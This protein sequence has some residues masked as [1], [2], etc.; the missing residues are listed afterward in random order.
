MA[1]AGTSSGEYL[2]LQGTPAQTATSTDETNPEGSQS[3]RKKRWKQKKSKKDN[4]EKKPKKQK[5][6]GKSVTREK[7]TRGHTGKVLKRKY[8]NEERAEAEKRSKKKKKQKQQEGRQQSQGR[9]GHEIESTDINKQTHAEA[10]PST[11]DADPNGLVRGET[12]H[13]E[14]FYLKIDEDEKKNRKGKS[15]I[16][17]K[18]FYDDVKDLLVLNSF[19]YSRLFF[20]T[21]VLYCKHTWP[22]RAKENKNYYNYEQRFKLIFKLKAVGGSRGEPPP[23]EKHNEMYLVE[24][25][26]WDKY[27]KDPSKFPLRRLC[28]Y[29]QVSARTD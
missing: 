6:G 25:S 18:A 26:N 28:C 29:E 21:A 3:T 9:D 19:D 11:A 8:N 20:M 15:K 2:E 7:D 12:S 5:Q 10:N 17:T 4:K 14:A 24:K 13:K 1:S 16:M 23:A 22:K 27:K